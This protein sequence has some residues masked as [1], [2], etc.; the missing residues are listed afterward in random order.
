[1]DSARAKPKS[2][3]SREVIDA[4]LSARA[5]FQRFLIARTGSE[6]EAEDL[7]Q[8]SLLKALQ[9]GAQ[10]RRGEKAVPWLYRI[11]RNAIADY[12]RQKSSNQRRT[13]RLSSDLR[14]AGDDTAAPPKDWNDA[15]RRCFRGLLPGLKP[16]YAELIRRI[17]LNGE[18]KIAVSRELRIKVGTLDVALHRARYALRRRLEVLCSACSREKLIACFCR[19]KTPSNR[20]A[21]IS[22]SVMNG[23]P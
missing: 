14:A 7:L 10:L 15:V 12:Y 20:E 18:P 3:P 6:T 17:D 11:L 1:M 22:P 16:R 21:V 9:H 13:D 5:R 8:Q 19:R 23:I 4:I 2:V